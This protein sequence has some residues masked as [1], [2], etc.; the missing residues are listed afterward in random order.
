MALVSP[1]VE[2][3]LAPEQRLALVVLVDLQPRRLVVLEPLIDHRRSIAGR[4]VAV[5]VD[6][7]AELDLAFDAVELVL[8]QLTPR[9]IARLV[10]VSLAQTF[11][12]LVVDVERQQQQQR[13]VVD[14]R[15]TCF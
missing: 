12:G 11:A 13:L 5:S 10:V 8:A 4:F 3:E 6:L 9:C 1:I 14:Y 15:T 2:L 7:A